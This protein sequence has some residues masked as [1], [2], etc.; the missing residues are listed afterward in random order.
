MSEPLRINCHN[1]ETI[2]SVDE[3]KNLVSKN[4]HLV[5]QFPRSINPS[6]LDA[7]IFNLE[8]HLHNYSVFYS[9]TTQ[10]SVNLTVKKV[11]DEEIVLA[12]KDLFIQAINSYF[13]ISDE[14]IF[15]LAKALN[16]PREDISLD[17][18]HE[19]EH[20]KGNTKLSGNWVY[21]FHGN[22]CRFRNTATGQVVDMRLEDF[23]NE[24]AT[25]D[26]YFFSEFI[27]TTSTQTELSVLLNDGFHDTRRVF[28]I[29]ENTGHLKRK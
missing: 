17:R 28:D 27:Q 9:G 1:L 24:E 10:E 29:L 16:L 14:L 25:P 20:S 5:L 22:E 8:N 11:I 21:L 2:P 23:G 7:T 12:N 3:I 4:V 26:P 13:K 19:A 15:K 6:N 18:L